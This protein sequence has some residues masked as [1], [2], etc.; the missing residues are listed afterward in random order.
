[1]RLYIIGNGFDLH[2]GLRTSYNYYRDFLLEKSSGVVRD[3]ESFGYFLNEYDE[4]EKL[5]SN[6]EKSLHFDYSEFAYHLVQD[7]YPD[8]NDES[9]S[10][11]DNIYVESDV[12]TEFAYKFV[13]EYFYE[14]IEGESQRDTCADLELDKD[15]IYLSFNYTD[16]LTRIYEIK[17]ENILHIHGSIGERENGLEFGSIE[18]VYQQCED[19]LVKEYEND[20]FYGAS[21]ESAV[22][23]LVEVTKITSK[24][25]KQNYDRLSEFLHGHNINEI[26]IMGHS[27]SDSEYDNGYYE[28]VIIPFVASDTSWKIYWYDEENK[29]K[30]L[31]FVNMYGIEEYELIKW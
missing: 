1:M 15:G 8:M 25:I 21:I 19:D 14:W 20:D 12:E 16:T 10:R 22:K 18:N 9:D 3:F 30:I 28:D 2:H 6:L 11:W 31:S 29:D 26:I 5:W 4:N 13:G 17:P 24:N 23:K 7:F 27:I